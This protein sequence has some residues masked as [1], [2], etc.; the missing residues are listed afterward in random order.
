MDD[1]K[2]M[3]RDLLATPAER[4]A[5]LHHGSAKAKAPPTPEQRAERAAALALACDMLK[6]IFTACD[7]DDDVTGTLAL[8]DAMNKHTAEELPKLI[9]AVMHISDATRKLVPTLAL[10][11]VARAMPQEPGAVEEAKAQFTKE[12]REAKQR[13]TA[14]EN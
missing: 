2:K 13:D 9:A 11:M 8:F 7:T 12:L 14:E 3:L 4:K 6:E 5:T 10:L 1:R